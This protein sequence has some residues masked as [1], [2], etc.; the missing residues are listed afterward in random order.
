MCE[1]QCITLAAFVS[2][3]DGFIQGGNVIIIKSFL[4][5]F[6][7]GTLHHSTGWDPHTHTHASL[8][9]PIPSTHPADEG[10]L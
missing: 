6:W 1:N 8:E 3:L 9:T 10:S 7:L 4:A 2:K 5:R